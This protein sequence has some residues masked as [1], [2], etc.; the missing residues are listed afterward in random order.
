MHLSGMAYGTEIYELPASDGGPFANCQTACTS[1]RCGLTS[2][3]LDI[4]SFVALSDGGAGVSCTGE[5]TCGCGTGRRP[6]SLLAN[7]PVQTPHALGGYLAEAARLEAASVPAFQLLARELRAHRAPTRLIDDALRS[8]QD[9]VRHARA[10]AS[11]ARR[12]GAAP[13]RPRFGAEPAERSLEVIATENAMEGCVRET[14]GALVALWQARHAQ[15]PAIASTMAPIAADELRHA[16]LAWKVAAWAAPRLS[17]AARF[18]VIDARDRAFVELSDE[19]A[20]PVPPTLVALAGL[21]PTETAGTLVGRL[22][23]AT[24]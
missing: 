6:A 3:T 15:D 24:A 14:Y 9:E 12:Y 20:L 16:E 23:R 18:R 10:T 21:P 1:I 11:L 2:Y 17:R 19:T 4:C 5:F 8:A 7:S 13:L 22:S